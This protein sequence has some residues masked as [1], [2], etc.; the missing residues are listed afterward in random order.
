MTSDQSDEG[1]VSSDVWLSAHLQVP[2]IDR[3]EGMTLI[4]DGTLVNQLDLSQ[5]TQ[6]M[7]SW[8]FI[9]AGNSEDSLSQPVLCIRCQSARDWE[10][11]FGRGDWPVELELNCSVLSSI[12]PLHWLFGILKGLVVPYME[13]LLCPSESLFGCWSFIFRSVEFWQITPCIE[14]KSVI[15]DPNSFSH[16]SLQTMFYDPL[17]VDQ[18]M[19][20]I[21]SR[22]TYRS[23]SDSQYLG[24]APRCRR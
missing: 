4:W 15:V 22:E 10:L 13:D 1:R 2:R 12:F 8:R 17:W 19:G 24:G 9:L 14:S 21:C 6:D 20:E 11:R 16:E 5:I 7:W 3:P 23:F 18:R